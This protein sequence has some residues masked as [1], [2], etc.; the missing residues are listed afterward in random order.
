VRHKA[1]DDR[2]QCDIPRRLR[3][4]PAILIIFEA[5]CNMVMR[6]VVATSAGGTGGTSVALPVREVTTHPAKGGIASTGS[7]M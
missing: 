1:L 2:L 5:T 6:M 4:L 3:L 7:R